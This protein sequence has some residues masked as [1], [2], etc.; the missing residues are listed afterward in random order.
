[1]VKVCV[2][3]YIKDP[4]KEKLREAIKNLLELYPMSRIKASSGLMHLV[5]EM[6]LYVTNMETVE[7]PDEFFDKTF[8]RQ[9]MLGTEEARRDNERVKV[10]HENFAEFRFEG[11]RYK[12]DSDM[13]TY[14]AMKY[15]TNLKNHL[16][17]N[18]ERFMKRVVFALYPGIS[19]NGKW[20]IINGITNDRKYEDEVEF[21]DRKAS[22]ESTNE[23]SA[24]RA[25]LQ[26]HRPLLGLANP[27]DKIS[28]LKKDKERYYR[29]V[30]RYFVFLDRELER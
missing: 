2:L 20:A 17:E 21:V 12:G 7:I 5:K 15:I 29:L 27:T 16:T 14:G 24:I 8:I 11:T 18:L 13:Y 1:V 9:L 25:V 28:E 22:K 23:A 26:E 19:Y 30:L 6:Y 3:K 4:Y 10:L